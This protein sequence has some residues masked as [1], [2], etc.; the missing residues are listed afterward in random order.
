[1]NAADLLQGGSEGD[2]DGAEQAFKALQAEVASMR[3]QL[4]LVHR[5][6][7][8]ARD[9]SMALTPDYTLTLDAK[10][11]L[12]LHF[13]APL[14]QPVSAG[15]ALVMQVYDP[16]YFVAFDFEKTSPISLTSAPAGCSLRMHDPQPLTDTSA[17][18]RDR[19]A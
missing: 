17:P 3:Q 10:K 6:G 7:E 11:L 8:Q 5:Q 18:R 4:E 9:A 15:K 14:K 2:E 12:T 13:T 19:C 1:M 16:T